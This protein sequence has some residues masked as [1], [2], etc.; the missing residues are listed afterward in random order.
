MI[1]TRT[2]CGQ[3]HIFKMKVKTRLQ[4]AMMYGVNRKT[5]SRWLKKHNIDIPRGLVTPKDQKRIFKVFGEVG[6]GNEITHEILEQ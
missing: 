4:L 5:F 3:E 2:F 6:G 1:R